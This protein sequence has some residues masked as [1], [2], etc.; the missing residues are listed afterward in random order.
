MRYDDF[1][2]F[3]SRP[4][5]NKSRREFDSRNLRGSGESDREH[6][7][8]NY[9]SEFD[10]RDG[11]RSDREETRR[12]RDDEWDWYDDFDRYNWERTAPN[13]AE[14][15]AGGHRKKERSSSG[16]DP[17]RDQRS[18]PPRN[19]RNSGRSPQGDRGSAYERAA[20]RNGPNGRSGQGGRRPNEGRRPPEGQRPRGGSAAGRR[21]PE[22]QRRSRKKKRKSNLLPVVLVV[23]LLAVVA[24]VV[25]S[26]VG[27]GGKGD[28]QIQFSTQSIV[29]GETAQATITG[30]PSGEDPVITWSSSDTNVVTVNDTG[31]LSA[32]SEGTATIAATI[33]GRSVSGTV[34]VV[35]TA[36]GVKSI[37][38]SEEK[39][40]V[41][42]GESHTIQ[43]TVNME[44]GLSPASVTWTSN[45]ASVARVSSN[46]VVTARD[47]GTTIVKATAGNKTAECVITVVENPDATKH[48]ESKTTGQAADDESGD[49]TG[50]ATGSKK[51]A[52]D[53]TDSGKDTKDTKD[54][55]DTEGTGTTSSDKTLSSDITGTTST[56]TGSSN[57]TATTD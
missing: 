52:T 16:R 4:S 1:D 38:L 53:K 42:S 7:S 25:K 30:I 46:G 13:W 29:V 26:C 2:D 43:A 24:L 51:T 44:E 36:V 49:G 17:Q 6:H 20:D 22:Y 19:D 54:A 31:L 21:P 3:D 37:T 32:K 15:S 56:D 11:Y 55:K 57:D 33:E 9:G 40:T 28:Y 34:M 35:K 41:V 48:D 39:A 5:R 18:R 50:D 14:R 27:N 8:R 10:R 12:L 47:V 23:I 45:D